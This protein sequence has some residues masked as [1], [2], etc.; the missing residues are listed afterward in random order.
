MWGGVVI[1]T[2]EKLGCPIGNIAG[3]I[4]PPGPPPLPTPPKPPKPPTPKPP[5]PKPKPAGNWR[6]I[7]CPYLSS[8]VKN[9][10]LVPDKNGFIRKDQTIAAGL[11]V[12]IS[13]GLAEATARGNFAHRPKV[14]GV[15]GTQTINVFN[16]QE[17]GTAKEHATSIG[18]RDALAPDI[19]LFEQYAGFCK[20]GKMGVPEVQDAINFFRNRSNDF[21]S[22]ADLIGASNTALIQ[23]FGKPKGFL[24]IDELRALWMNSEYPRGFVTSPQY[25]GVL[26][27]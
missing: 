1:R 16:M 14:N 26:K 22:G 25:N 12:G 3:A 17:G 20:G 18:I 7:I 27:R 11:R 5:T 23:E 2:G 21:G 6:T 8:L 4:A 15:D 9:G 19:A 10:D 13:P 24:T